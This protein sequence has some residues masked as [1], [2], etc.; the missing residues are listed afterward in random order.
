[1]TAEAKELKARWTGKGVDRA[2][3]GIVQ[4]DHARHVLVD[5]MAD[6]AL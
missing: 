4:T 6:K 1:M 5:I 3:V 2:G